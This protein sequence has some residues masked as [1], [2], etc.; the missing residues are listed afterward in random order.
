MKIISF[1]AYTFSTNNYFGA[2]DEG[3]GRGQWSVF[4]QI[5]TRHNAQ[6]SLTGV[7][8]SER[9]VPVVFGYSGADTY[10]TAFLRLLGQLD[11]ANPYP[12]RLVAQ[13]NN[14]ALVQC[15]AIVT[16]PGGATIEG[17]VNMLRVV[18]VTPDPYWT[19][20]TK[21]TGGAASWSG[22]TSFTATLNN[23]GSAYVPA[24]FTMVLS[25][26]GGGTINE[27]FNYYPVTITNNT[28]RN[29]YKELVSID[30]GDTTAAS[31]FS[32]SATHCNVYLEG[33][34]QP[35]V[36]LNYGTL[37]TYVVVP[38]TIAAGDSRV[39]EVVISKSATDSDRIA[40]QA[41][42][43]TNTR[44]NGNYTPVYLDGS[45][46]TATAGTSTTL[47]DSTKTWRTVGGWAGGFVEIVSGTGAGQCRR[48]AS[49]TTTA[50]TVERAFTTTPD[51]T[52]VYAIHTSGWFVDGGQ[53]SSASAGLLTDS[54]QSW[55]ADTLVGGTIYITAGT[56]SGQNR[57][58]T[59]NTATTVTPVSNFSPTP[60][61]TSVYVIRK[62][63]YHQ[64]NVDQTDTTVSSASPGHRHGGWQLS[65]R[66]TPPTRL[67]FGGDCIAGWRRA[68][69]LDNRDDFSQRRW[70]VYTVTS[71]DY[72][73]GILN[74]YRYRG[75]DRRIQEE[76][77]G[78]G[79][80]ITSA[81]GYQGI[82]FDY[83][84]QN[85]SGV[86]KFVVGVREAG[87][88]DWADILVDNTT[89]ATL[90][91]VAV[92]YKTFSGFGTPTQIYMGVLPF[93]GAEIPSTADA[94]SFINV[95]WHQTLRLHLV[96][97]A[98][99]ISVGAKQSRVRMSGEI[100]VPTTYGATVNKI[101]YIGRSAGTDRELF[102]PAD[103]STQ[104]VVDSENG[105]A[106]T[107]PGIGLRDDCPWAVKCLADGVLTSV[108]MMIPP[109]TNTFNGSNLPTK[110]SVTFSA[111]PK[112][113]G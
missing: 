46:G 70:T 23:T 13:L 61:N 38:V 35:S 78:D 50:I 77:T 60:D 41:T 93:D 85:V 75:A 102:L 104:L 17:D 56:G 55:D 68:T 9:I 81:I 87:S 65:S 100:A 49:N 64:Y 4:P 74:A 90:T 107:V 94:S 22:T 58:I 16:T 12:R 109:G 79:V 40:R 30:I 99:T 10:E 15:D 63:G 18:F 24:S 59:A 32:T 27:N 86:G 34:Q 84:M 28:E 89:R 108:W 72:Y 98:V 110:G 69:Y 29:F 43:T 47:T 8:I 66:R 20:Q 95:L 48:I 3:T 21:V 83:K 62:H 14:G 33:V 82:R 92:Q 54:S 113:F 42:I 71:V 2:L 26:T 36:P 76:G 103:G 67:A 88:E 11:P 112:H 91:N 97:N 101:I 6:G 106:Y 105:D 31:G 25:G 53:A 57:A 45:S 80:A 19:A 39:Y 1:D 111:F 37:R 44:F 96:G 73:T 52:S 51:N 5:R 7:Q